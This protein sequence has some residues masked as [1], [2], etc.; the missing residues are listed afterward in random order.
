M[1]ATPASSYNPSRSLLAVIAVIIVAGIVLRFLAITPTWIH[2]DENYYLN[3][4][5][6]FIE[7]GELTPYMWRLDPD[8][9]IIA[10]SGTGYGVLL[11]TWWQA[12]FGV[13]LVGVRVLMVLV[14]LTTAAMMYFVG[15]VWWS[16]RAAGVAT[17]IVAVV[18]TSPFYSYLARMDALGMLSYSV[19]LLLHVLAVRRNSRWLHFA[20]GVAVVAT[21]EF[22]ILGVLYLAGITLYMGIVYLR[23]VI[24][25]KRLALNH[26]AIFYGVG[27][28]M[29]GLVYIAVH[30][31]PDP[32]AYFVISNECFQCSGTSLQKEMTRWT[33]FGVLRGLEVPL[34]VIGL[35]SVLSRRSEEDWHYLAVFGG[36]LVALSLAGPPPFTHYTYHVWPLVALG[37]GGFIARGF[38][39]EGTLRQWRVSTGLTFALFM[40]IANY[41][42]HLLGFQPFELRSD[43]E[44]AD[45]AEG[46]AFIHANIPTDTVIMSDVLLFHPLKDYTEFMSYRNGY[47]YGAG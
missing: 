45:H 19:A 4:G 1:S 46:I 21:A 39:R 43:T 7:H 47:E 10:G 2:Y 36:W 40:L 18:S 38:Q 15:A 5:V 28:L 30:I 32:A 29:A 26:E 6:N 41:G 11:L 25:E 20:T 44:Y 37:V 8:S 9:N 12:L 33:R 16:S 13:T 22:H 3:I 14:G 34:L 35:V 17:A 24:A 31:L 23:D 42:L 27:G